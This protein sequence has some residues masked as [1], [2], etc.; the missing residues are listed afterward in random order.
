MPKYDE[1]ETKKT[2]SQS[3]TDK[4]KSRQTSGEGSEA[5]AKG[6]RPTRLE[7]NLPEYQAKDKEYERVLEED[8][9]RAAILAQDRADIAK[10]K[11]TAAEKTAE[12]AEDEAKSSK[13]KK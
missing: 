13:S 5:K 6:D 4:E 2:E 12:D 1:K 7:P 8:K 9:Q 11:A 3:Q 10:A